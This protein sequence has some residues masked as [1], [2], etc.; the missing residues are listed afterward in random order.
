MPQQLN[1]RQ[2]CSTARKLEQ[3]LLKNYDRVSTE[4]NYLH[5]SSAS[6]WVFPDGAAKKKIQ[7]VHVLPICFWPTKLVC[8]KRK[9]PATLT[10]ARE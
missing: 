2:V 1:K 9:R 4:V 5:I 3:L 8:V 7:D 6:V 10:C